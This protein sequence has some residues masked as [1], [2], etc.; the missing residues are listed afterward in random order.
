M[1]VHLN[2]LQCDEIFIEAVGFSS[3]SH[4]VEGV[5]FILFL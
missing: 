4:Y 2:A 5:S 1:D 3:F